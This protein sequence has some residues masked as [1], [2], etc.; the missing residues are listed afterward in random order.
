M[1]LLHAILEKEFPDSRNTIIDENPQ[2]E[3]TFE[4]NYQK[5]E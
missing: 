4:L 1:S 2:L 5:T 3:L